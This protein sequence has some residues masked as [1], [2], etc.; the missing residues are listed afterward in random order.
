MID[1]DAM[2]LKPEF[3]NLEPERAAAFREL[4]V[5]LDGKNQIEALKEIM[6]FSK[7]TPKGRDFSKQ[8]QMLMVQAMADSLPPE[9]RKR[10]APILKMFDVKV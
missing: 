6:D 3:K 1:I 9:E 8:E 4:A 10:Y 5:R 2:L 7:K